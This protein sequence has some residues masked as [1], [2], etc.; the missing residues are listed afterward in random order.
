MVWLKHDNTY[1]TNHLQKN[2]QSK[3]INDLTPEDIAAITDHTFLKTED[4]F[5]KHPKGSV[6]GRQEAFDEFL[7]QVG[8]LNPYAVCVRHYDL[9]YT[10]KSLEALP[11]LAGRP[12]IAAVV[13]FPNPNIYVT[14]DQFRI[15]KNEISRSSESEASEIDF[16]LPYNGPR[17]GIGGKSIFG[18]VAQVNEFIQSRG[19]RSK[20]ILEI[21]NLTNEQI[22]A[23]CKLAQ[24]EGIDFV[25]T[26]TG[27]SQSGATPEA[28]K[29]MR[30]NFRMGVKISGGVTPDNYHSLLQA[31]NFDQSEIIELDP[32]RIRI[33]ASSLLPALYSKKS[34]EAE[35]Y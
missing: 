9:D 26:S 3:A 16:V 33:G 4:A 32:S 25:K 18:Y 5:T 1:I 23:T 21:S 10:S 14:S 20:L 11:R 28:L 31:A 22:E 6:F 13:G 34:V 2:M 30:S 19:M 35:Q 17:H 8:S 29:L 7:S 15:V 24:S 12:L 27:Y